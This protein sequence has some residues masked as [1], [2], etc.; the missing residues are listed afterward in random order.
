MLLHT[1]GSYLRGNF[2]WGEYLPGVISWNHF[3]QSA[4]QVYSRL[5]ADF[6]LADQ[7]S[8]CCGSKSASG[9]VASPHVSGLQNDTVISGFVAVRGAAVQQASHASSTELN[10]N[11]ATSA[12]HVICPSPIPSHPTRLSMEK[13]VVDS[14]L[15]RD[16]MQVRPMLSCGVCPSV[17]HVRAFCQNE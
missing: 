17:C 5:T 13:Y 15:P 4:V 10:L 2:L 16:A 7:P 8:S 9:F 11:F 14:K 6:D 12:C 1:A 3:S